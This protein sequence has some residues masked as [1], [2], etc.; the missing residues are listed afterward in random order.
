M[1]VV[2]GCE[3][4]KN[5]DFYMDPRLCNNIIILTWVVAGAKGCM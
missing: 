3:R 1:P 2:A 5:R 4:S